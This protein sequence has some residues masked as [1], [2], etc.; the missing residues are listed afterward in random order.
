MPLKKY[1]IL[2]GTAIGHLR[3]ADGDDYQIL[4]RARNTLH[5]IAVNV[6]SATKNTPSVVLFQGSHSAHGAVT[7]T[8]M[9]WPLTS[10]TP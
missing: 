1:G 6:K 3:D 5:R 8:S 9:R 10:E 7:F 4:I 2:K